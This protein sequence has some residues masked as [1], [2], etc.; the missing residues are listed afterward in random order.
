[1]LQFLFESVAL[2]GI[3]GIVGIALGIL[4]ATVIEHYAGM[5]TYVTPMS[6]I[7]AFSV[8]VLTGVVFGTNPACKA[9][10][11]SPIEALRR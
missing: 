11:L 3:G 9:A 2:T 1:M 8:S 5:T 6:V 4:M 10:S 7:L